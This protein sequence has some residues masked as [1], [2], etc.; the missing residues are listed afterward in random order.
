MGDRGRK[1]AASMEV[2][3]INVLAVE[4]PDAPYDLTDAQAEVWRTVVNGLPAEWFPR[5]TWPLL[6]Q[7]CRHVVS[8]EHVAKLIYD[9]E[10]KKDG[11]DVGEY[12]QLLIMQ[13]REGRALS[14]LATRMRMTQ[15]STYDRQKMKP[16]EAKKLWEG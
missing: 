6:A 2:A 1:S 16:K 4:R 5:E 12:N 10:Q 3:P 9:L 11:F 13:E 7:Y 8:A 15:Q 14:S